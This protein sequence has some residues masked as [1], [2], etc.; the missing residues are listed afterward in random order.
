MSPGP[1]RCGCCEAPADG[2]PAPVTNRSGLPAI[3]YRVGTSAS[4]RQAMIEAAGRRPELRGWTSRAP[5]DVGM[6]LLA[7][8]AVIGDVLTFYQE[9]IANEA[10]L[11]TALL[12]ESV[13]RLTALLGYEPAP[14]VAA[15]ADLVFTLD[16]GK[17]VLLPAGLQVQSVPREGE[18]PELF[19]TT[20]QVAA[21]ARLNDIPIGPAP[22]KRPGGALAATSEHG[23]LL[24]PAELGPGD[25]VLVV[26]GSATAAPAPAV[27]EKIVTAV[28][29]EAGRALLTWS[30]PIRDP[31]GGTAMRRWTRRFLLFGHDAPATYLTSTVNDESQVTWTSRQ[32]DF[33]APAEPAV[34]LDSIVDGIEPGTDILLVMGTAAGSTVQVLRVTGVGPA[35]ASIGASGDPAPTPAL[36]ATVT[37]LDLESPSGAGVTVPID[38][39]TASVYQLAGPAITFWD[40]E[41]PDRFGGDAA[42]MPLP[43][44]PDLAAVAPGL[45][46]RTVILDDAQAQPQTVTLIGAHR[47]DADG[48]GQPDHLELRFTPDLGREL[49]TATATLFG[50]VARATHGE[51]V[52]AE[53]LG[54]GDAATGLQ[55]FRLAKR[56]LTYVPVPGAPGG[57]ASTL[58]IEADGTTWRETPTLFGRGPDEPVYTLRRDDDGAT[59]VRFGDGSTGARLPTGR[60]NVIAGYRAGLG[61]SGRVRA[62]SLTTPRTRPVGLRRVTNPAAASGGADPSSPDRIRIDA[63]NTVRTFGRIV[64]LRDFA[65]AARETAVVG[66]ARAA[67]VWDGEE[68]VVQLTV[69]GV[70]GRELAGPELELLVADLNSRRDPNRALRVVS[71]DEVPIEVVAVLETADRPATAVLAA[72]RAAVLDLLAFDRREFGQPVHASDVYR[73]LQET[74]GVVAVRV[75]R[76]RRNEPADRG[77]Q[78]EIENP[79]PVGPSQLAM[80][81]DPAADLDIGIG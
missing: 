3:R 47:V 51:T 30:P 38:V 50:N 11:R 32:T 31:R 52:A 22:E 17:D 15:V 6:A 62:G 66:K 44:R 10:F 14:G 72:A 40:F 74:E 77:G 26:V 13:R 69:A 24:A 29:E 75:T 43:V 59:V 19:E 65:D 21:D 4:F 9:R 25:Q 2:T 45:L 71:H 55:S 1:C 20:V 73:V 76:L 16:D 49:D 37:K 79:I 48:D 28:G 60:G 56:P 70:D 53:V 35:G 27:E 67:A 46:G 81:R 5:D 63:P 41:Y 64:S 78:P 34:Y 58:Q 61:S 39:R 42:Y 54:D 18:R 57:A 36:E 12:P 23:V 7:M 8:W 80:F 33:T 68:Q